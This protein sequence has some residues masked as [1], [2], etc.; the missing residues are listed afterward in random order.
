MAFLFTLHSHMR[1]LVAGVLVI[2]L[3]KLAATWMRGAQFGRADRALSSAAIGLIDLQM[4]LGIILLLF[5]DGTFPRERI[6]HAVTMILAVVAA[7]MSARWKRAEGNVRARN[8]YI[9]LLVAALL[10]AV[11]VMRLSG[12]GWMRGM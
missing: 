2:A 9:A 11:G 3:V 5:L 7:H 10:I 4:L 8:T 6:E 1:W 12:G